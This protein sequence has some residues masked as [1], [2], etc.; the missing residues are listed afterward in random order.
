[1]PAPSKVS[2]LPEAIRAELERRLIA[3]GFGGY[4]ELEAWLAAQ[5]FEI[6]KSSLHRDGAKL[7][8]RLEAIKA[9]TEAARTLAEAAP[10]DEGHLSGSVISMVQSDIFNVLLKL[11][12]AQDDEVNPTERLALLSAA[13]K[14]VAELTR[15]SVNQKKWMTEVRSRVKAAAD[16][17]VKIAKKG[18]LSAEAVSELRAR[19]L[20]VAE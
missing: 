12:D 20:G 11:Q 14:S 9:S 2:L 15:A 17:A 8:R 19:I 16:A 3:S 4:E 1:M 13:A 10:D 6:G 7:K 5:G 18:G